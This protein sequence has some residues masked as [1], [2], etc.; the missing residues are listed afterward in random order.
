MGWNQLAITRP[1]PIFAELDGGDYVY[2]VHSYYPQ[3]ADP[4]L[5]AASTSYGVE[6]TSAVWR[7]NLFATQFHPEKSQQV[8]LKILKAFGSL[9]G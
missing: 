2:F 3:P 1:A 6:F 7:D 4:A 9:I 5:Q 8:G